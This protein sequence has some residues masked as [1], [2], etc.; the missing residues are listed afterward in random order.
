MQ[1]SHNEL[2]SFS[3]LCHFTYVTAHSST[4]LS[5]LLRHRIFTYVTWRAAHW[6]P[7]IVDRT[8]TNISK[9]FTHLISLSKFNLPLIGTFTWPTPP[10]PYRATTCRGRKWNYR[11][12]TYF[13][14]HTRTWR[15]SPDEWSAQ[16]RG[17]LRDSTNMK[18]NTHEAQTQSSQQD[19]YGMV[20]TTVK[21]YSGP[22]VSWHLSY[23][24]GKTPKKPHPGNLSRPS[25]LRDSGGL[26]YLTKKIN[27]NLSLKHFRA[28]GIRK[29]KKKRRPLKVL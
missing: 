17:H 7:L 25:P 18:D 21:W 26:K 6:L 29:W 19:E 12:H 1:P 9:H 28:L 24:W 20:I 13:F 22:K 2:C 27:L 4:L 14:D 10:G 16:C 3:K 8:F 5:L 23:R 11:S 15:S